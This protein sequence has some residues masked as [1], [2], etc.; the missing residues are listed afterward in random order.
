M[1]ALEKKLGISKDGESSQNKKRRLDDDEYIEQSKEIVDSVKSAVS[2]GIVSTRHS[3]S[4]LVDFITQL[5][6]KRR[7]KSRSATNPPNPP[8]FRSSRRNP[9]VN[10]PPS[11]SRPN[12]CQPRIW[13]PL[14]PDLRSP[15]AIIVSPRISSTSLD[16][17]ISGRMP[18]VR[19]RIYPESQRMASPLGSS[20]LPDILTI[21]PHMGLLSTTLIDA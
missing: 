18:S 21:C 7:R 1:E 5:Y 17:I 20:S 3:S 6:S 19:T 4:Y 14:V 11:R 8:T 13:L 9:P 10:H 2:A 12:P 16:S 15:L